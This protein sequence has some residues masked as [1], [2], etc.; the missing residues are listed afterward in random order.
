MIIS[1]ILLSTCAGK[2]PNPIPQH[3][4]G[5]EAKQKLKCNCTKTTNLTVKEY[6]KIKKL[7]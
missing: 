5:D 4:S 7:V 3:Q 2:T 6:T 1:V